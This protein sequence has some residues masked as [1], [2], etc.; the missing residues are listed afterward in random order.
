M[1]EHEQQREELLKS[2]LLTNETTFYTWLEQQPGDRVFECDDRTCPIAQWLDAVHPG[3][4]HA[5]GVSC[6]HARRIVD[7]ARGP[8]CTLPLWAKSFVAWFDT[9]ATDRPHDRMTTADILA[10]W[11]AA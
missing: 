1:D 2:M 9:L 4:A 5:V 3:Y 11:R 7:H 6:V 10:A 8:L